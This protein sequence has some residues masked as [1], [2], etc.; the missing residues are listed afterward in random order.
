MLTFYGYE[1]IQGLTIT[2]TCYSTGGLHQFSITKDRPTF[3]IILKDGG[4]LVSDHGHQSLEA[5]SMVVHPQ[6]GNS[7]DLVIDKVECLHLVLVT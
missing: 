1:Y 3:W 6:K 4:T 7:I 5:E 2:H